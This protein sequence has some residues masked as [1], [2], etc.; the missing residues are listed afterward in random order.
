M[1]LFALSALSGLL[2]ALTFPKFDL[3]WLAWF[4]FIPL[5]WATFGQTPQR[6]ALLGFVRELEELGV[7]CGTGVFGAHM[8]IEL[9]N[10]GPVTFSLEV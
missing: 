1:K 10:D 3:E 6:A 4:A 2:W 5:F 9:L 7:P 8:E